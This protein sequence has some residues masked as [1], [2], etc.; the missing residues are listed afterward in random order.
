[1]SR[2]NK[3]LDGFAIRHW[4]E[5]TRVSKGSHPTGAFCDSAAFCVSQIHFPFI[6]SGP[7]SSLLDRRQ[8]RT[9]SL[10]IVV[11]RTIAG[12]TSKPPGRAYVLSFTRTT[13]SRCNTALNNQTPTVQMQVRSMVWSNLTTARMPL[14]AGSVPPST[15]PYGLFVSTASKCCGRHHSSQ[16]HFERQSGGCMTISWPAVTP[17]HARPVAPGKPLTVKLSLAA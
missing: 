4:R 11:S 13:S 1:M 9:N 12:A 15:Q 3:V 14:L 7:S 5:T 17:G 2:G 10:G 6:P 8:C 16:A